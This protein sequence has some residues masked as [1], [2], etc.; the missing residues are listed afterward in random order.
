MIAALSHR[1]PDASAVY[2]DGP[3]AIANARLAILDVPGGA[4]PMSNE[5]RSL[6]IA[7]NG[8][9]FNY[10]ELRE[11]LVA[12]GHRFATDSD[13]EVLLRLFEDE[14]DACVHRLNGQWAFAV[15]DR[16]SNKLFLSR[17]RF[18]VRPLFYTK[19]PDCF[20][21]ASEI[22][23]LFVHRQV[24]RE[25]DI[26]A[27]DE[28]FTF[29]SALPPRTAFEDIFELSPGHSLWLADGKV[30]TRMY[31]QPGYHPAGGPQSAEELLELLRDATRL[32]VHADVPVGAYL[33]G[34]LDS[35]LIAALA[36]AESTSPLHT[37]SIAF[38]DPG[39]DERGHQS[40]AA[41]YLGTAHQ[42]LVCT[43]TD[44]QE[45]LPAVVRHAATPILRTAPAPMYLLSKL[46]RASGFKVVL[47]GEGADELFGG[48]DI[49]KETKIR[50]FWASQPT[51][52]LRPLLLSRLHPYLPGT[53]AQPDAYLQAF[54]RPRD[55]GPFFSHRPRWDLTS[56]LKVFFSGEVRNRLTV[57]PLQRE[58]AR[59]PGGFETWDWLSQAQFLETTMLLP[60]YILSSQGD[61]MAMAHSVETRHPFLDPR[62]AAFAARLPASDKIKVLEE[63]FLLKT[64]SKGLIPESIRRRLKQPFRAPE[65]KCFF[66][67][68]RAGY[69]DGLL[70]QRNLERSGLFHPG[71]VAKLVQKF[72]SGAAIG[73][74]DNMAMVGIVSTLLLQEELCGN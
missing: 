39:F 28:V 12:R 21:F 6:W 22:P 33:S 53:P 2:S 23:A 51:S 11:R 4:Q 61:R 45:A 58:A 46:V 36:Q 25:I 54:Y 49:F 31:W 3:A 64:A 43:A 74:K 19:L 42:Q 65:A 37:F 35:T 26:Q 40:E 18:G 56:R 9:I 70:C 20:L 52:K 8:E 50:R 66:R 27:L 16:R 15:W 60:G 59:L 29:W 24:R 1:G 63:K 68:K 32:R 7:F 72:E 48:Y 34:G 71:A 57:D 13:T 44:I 30:E 47:T 10:L 41:R 17:D 73:I 69:L 55:P 67:P 5:D 38:D 62:V 14:G